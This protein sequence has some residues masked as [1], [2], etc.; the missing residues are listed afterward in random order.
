MTPQPTLES[1]G[2]CLSVGVMSPHMVCTCDMEIDRISVVGVTDDILTA[3]L[4]NPP[5]V[6]GKNPY[7]TAVHMLTDSTDGV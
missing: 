5:R 7:N 3:R 6:R 4:S 1:V 2:K